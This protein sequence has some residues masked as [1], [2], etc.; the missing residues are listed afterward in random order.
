MNEHPMKECPYCREDILVSAVKCRYCKTDLEVDPGEPI[1]RDLPGRIVAGVAVYIAKAMGIS[2]SLVRVIFVVTT[3]F[4][5]PLTL[6]IY[7]A[8]WLIVPFRPD[9][10]SS[11]EKLVAEGKRRYDR[12]KKQPAAQEDQTES[13]STGTALSEA[14]EHS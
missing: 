10:Q 8:V 11:L 4:L 13:A 12:L 6:S 9:Q 7:L 2:V 14:N 3:I 1:C 5:A